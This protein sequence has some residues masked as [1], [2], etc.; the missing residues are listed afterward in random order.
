MAQPVEV[1]QGLLDPLVVL[2]G[3]RL[4]RRGDLGDAVRA[5]PAEDDN[6]KQR[7]GAKAVGAVHTRAGSLAGSKQP[8]DDRVGVAGLRVDDLAEVVRRDATHVVVHRRQRRDRLLRHVHAGEDL[9]R[10]GD[11]G[12]ALVQ[13]VGRQVVK[14]Q[15]DVVL[16]RA[17][18][19]ALADLHGHGAAD[20]IARRQVLGAGRV[21]L[22]EALALRVLQD[23]SLAT[24]SLSHEAAGT[25]DT[26]RV[27]LHELRVLDGEAGAQSHATA[28]TGAGVGAGGAEVGAAVA[29]RREHGVLGLDAVQA[30]VLHVHHQHA[31][32][33]ALVVHDEVECE[34]LDEVVRVERQRAPIQRVEHRVARAIGSGGAAVR[35]AALAEVK[36]LPA[37]GALVDLALLRPRERQAVRLQ[38]DNGTR[39][40]TAHVVDGVLVAQ[41]VRSL[42]GIVHVPSPVV[43]RD[44]GQRGVDAALRRHRVRAR[45][46]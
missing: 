19:A 20:D 21:T 23:A 12:Q 41:P 30:A 7:V 1:V 40:L 29:A 31:A 38:L 2:R 46:E 13:H 22:H 42:D 4:A 35:L 34:V 28:V 45:G 9:R 17:H 33:H 27:E 25:V 44:V 10:L 14:V 26:G 32:A 16:L 24:A 3:Q 8:R 36:R 11:T 5:R 15:V 37:E 18:A 43:L 6:V 39:R